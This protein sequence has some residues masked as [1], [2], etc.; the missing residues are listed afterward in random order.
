MIYL[1]FTVTLWGRLNVCL[2]SRVMLAAHET[3]HS[4]CM[5]SSC[6]YQLKLLP[7]VVVH[8]CLTW[9]QWSVVP[10]TRRSSAP[11]SAT[12]TRQLQSKWP[13]SYC[14]TKPQQNQREI[15]V[16]C[17]LK[18]INQ[19]KYAVLNL[20]LIIS[21]AE[22]APPPC[23]APATAPG[24]PHFNGGVSGLWSDKNII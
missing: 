3:N 20:R 15:T 11:L 1:Y 2:C 13:P 6:L 4:V 14:Q 10:T 24:F 22:P 8:R 18:V 5:I 9:G 16:Y 19:K 7:D 23:T 12:S 21:A 17:K